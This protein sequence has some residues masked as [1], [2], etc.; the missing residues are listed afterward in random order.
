MPYKYNGS[1]S[2]SFGR[3]RLGLPKHASPAKTCNHRTPVE[4]HA[5]G[6]G[7]WPRHTQTPSSLNTLETIFLVELTAPRAR[8]HNAGQQAASSPTADPTSI[9]VPP[10]RPVLRTP[11]VIHVPSGGRVAGKLGQNSVLAMM[12]TLETFASGGLRCRLRA[13]RRRDGNPK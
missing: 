1:L 8:G 6:E 13:T 3:R 5:N 11:R 10:F 2:S 12:G 4:R 9:C 7:D